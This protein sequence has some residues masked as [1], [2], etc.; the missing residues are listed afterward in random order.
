[1]INDVLRV[2][3]YSIGGI[4]LVSGDASKGLML[5]NSQRQIDKIEN[6]EGSVDAGNDDGEEIWLFTDGMNYSFSDWPEKF[7]S[8]KKY[9]NTLLRAI[10][11]D[12]N[13]QVDLSAYNEI[14]R[15]GESLTASNK[16]VQSLKD[17]IEKIS[18]AEE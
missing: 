6:L 13:F 2:A 18:E 11:Q 5:I 7:S 12:P 10:N 9:L 3:S 4:N 1:M 16:V 17:S 15:L 14:S 8:V